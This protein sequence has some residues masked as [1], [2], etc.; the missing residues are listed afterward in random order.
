MI[1]EIFYNY[2]IDELIEEGGMGSVYLG[3]HLKLKRQVA[4]KF[5]NPLLMNNSDVKERFKHEAITLSKLN[6]PNIVSIYDFIENDDG[7]YLV[8]EYIKGEPLNEYIDNTGPIHETKASQLFIKMLDAISYIHS[9]NILHRDIKP[10]NFIVT[11]GFNIKIIDFGIAKTVNKINKRLTKSGTKVGTTLYMSPQQVRGQVLDR[12]TDIYSLGITLFQ[13]LTGQ[14]PYDENSSE[15]DLYQNIVSEP[16]PDPKTFYIGVSDK[17][18]NIILKATEKKP[19]HRY[20][21]CNEFSAAIYN[22]LSNAKIKQTSLKT[23]I[24]DA[25]DLA[26]IKAPIFNRD[27]WRN[28]SVLLIT[29]TFIAAIG[30][31][32]HFVL[33]SDIRHVLSDKQNL[34]ANNKNDA[35]VIETLKYGETVKVIN[36]NFDYNKDNTWLKVISLRGNAGYI[37]KEKLAKPKLYEQINLMFGNNIAQQLT[38]INY[39][40]LLR[41]FFVN[42]RFIYK[43]NVTFK[44]YSESKK[45]FEYNT[46][47]EGDFNNNNKKDFACILQNISKKQYLFLIFFDDSVSPIVFEYSQKIKIKL[48]TKGKDGGLWYLGNMYESTKKNKLKT[49]VYEALKHDGIL[50]YNT[51]LK[52]NI[53]FILNLEETII[54]YFEQ[55]KRAL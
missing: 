53:V 26:L 44:L 32:I 9:K 47:I 36:S 52:T 28:L 25:A 35:E 42:E 19:L 48:I 22:T 55:P 20:Q 16:F 3:V 38:P 15:Y 17:M 29:V 54:T 24:I 39:K 11:S 33:K 45:N 8:M 23:K 34:Y 43:Q 5:L 30:I 40:K 41:N 1:G 10:S 37:S 7:I 21:S 12:R 6:H 49:N 51:H 18:K 46:I 50:L 2:R 14:Y 4:I 13:M 27:F 31:G